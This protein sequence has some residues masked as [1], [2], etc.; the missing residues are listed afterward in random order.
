MSLTTNKIYKHARTGNFYRISG[1]VEIKIEGEWTPGVLYEPVTGPSG[2]YVRLT[3]D[4]VKRFTEVTYRDSRD[5][6]ED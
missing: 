3:K 5:G 2:K 1:F 6:R 4:F